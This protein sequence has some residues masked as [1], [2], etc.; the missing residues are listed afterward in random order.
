MLIAPDRFYWPKLYSAMMTYTSGHV[1][2]K[3]ILVYILACVIFIV[4]NFG[5]RLVA[6]GS[7]FKN[8][9]KLLSA[10]PI[11]IFIFILI[12]AGV[13]VPML[14]IQ[15]GTPWN[16][17]Q[18]LYYSLFFSGIVAGVVLGQFLEKTKIKTILIYIIIAVVVAL[19]IPTTFASMNNYFPV[20]PQS[21]LPSNEVEALKFLSIQPDG[22]VLTYPFDQDK[23]GA[24][25]PPRPLYLYT[26]T[27]YVSAFSGKT[28]FLEDE[29]NL[30]I[31]Q[32]PWQERETSL[33]NFLKL[34]NTSTAQSFLKDNNIFYVYWVDDQQ[35]KIP[36]VN[37]G[38]TQIFKN[39][40]VTIFRVNK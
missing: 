5:T 33:E 39:S 36:S 37:L 22:V 14:F 9:K 6:I 7:F 28:T 4:G 26:S 38:L 12:S 10:G 25:I 8:P 13:V 35:A 11:E 19:T 34:V 3:A 24:A 2:G 40:G 20:K 1:W 15:K 18:F 32:Y 17:I 23:A 29:I 31:M 16:T 30:D 27:A 21:I